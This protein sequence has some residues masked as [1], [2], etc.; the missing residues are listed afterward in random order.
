MGEMVRILLERKEF[1]GGL[2]VQHLLMSLV[3]IGI[4]TIIGIFLGV[5]ISE[6]KK[7]KNFV[8]AA[9]NIIYT[10]PSI[11]ML[12]FLMPVTGIGNTTAIIMLTVYALLP[13]V[14][15]TCI[16]LEEVDGDTIEAA[17]GMGSTRNQILWRI[18]M[19]LAY[20]VIL[21]GFRSMVV[22]TISLA[23]IASYVGAGGLGVAIFR[24]ITTNNQPMILAGSVLVAVM[25]IGVDQ[26]IGFY[27]KKVNGRGRY[28]DES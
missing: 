14:R 23:G 10:I 16:G 5:L 11:S 25:A 7:I 4:S 1:F 8:I 28:R 19:P 13:I 9:V 27:E 26:L 24:G 21:A 3:S 18:R 2:I 17:A 15:N 22:M 12:G 20:P 6:Q